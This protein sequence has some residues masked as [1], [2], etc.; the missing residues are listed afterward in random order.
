MPETNPQ[1][2]CS[3]CGGAAF[4]LKEYV[5]LPGAGNARDLTPLNEVLFSGEAQEGDL[6]GLVFCKS[7]GAVA[8]S[9]SLGDVG[10]FDVEVIE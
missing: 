6:V 9:L 2:K 10:I 8:G 3:Q 1:P 5:R 4:A 7:C